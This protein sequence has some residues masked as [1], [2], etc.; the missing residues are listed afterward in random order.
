[1]VVCLKIGERHAYLDISG[2]FFFTEQL[3]TWAGKF[4][5]GI[6]W[7][8]LNNMVIQNILLVC[9]LVSQRTAAVLYLDFLYLFKIQQWKVGML[10][11]LE[12]MWIICLK[13]KSYEF[14]VTESPK[15]KLGLK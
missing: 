1:M 13:L 9:K 5:S 4:L 2:C 6:K 15:G 10:D 14:R 7:I 11:T 8:I 3:I 12:V